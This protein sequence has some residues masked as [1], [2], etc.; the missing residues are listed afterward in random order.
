MPQATACAPLG[1]RI[2]QR[3]DPG[4]ACEIVQALV[5]VS[6]RCRLEVDDLDRRLAFGD[7]RH[8][9]TAVFSQT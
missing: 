4:D 2:R 8:A 3:V 1:L 5:E 9:E 7:R 6:K